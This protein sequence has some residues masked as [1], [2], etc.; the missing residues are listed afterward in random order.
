MRGLMA[1]TFVTL[2]A[3]AG[4]SD[5]NDDDDDRSMAPAPPP[6]PANTTTLDLVLSGAEVVGGTGTSAT[7]TATITVDLDDGSLSGS[8]SVSGATAETVALH[9]GFGGD[10]GPVLVTLESS[11]G[12]WV[13]PDSVALSADEVDAFQNGGL[14]LL[15]TTA[16]APEG[17]LRGQLLPEGIVLLPV[18]LSGDQ[19]VPP[20]ATSASATA[21]VTFD[22]DGNDLVVHVNT[23]GLDD[24]VEAHVHE[25]VAGLNGPILVGLVQDPDDVSHWMLEEFVLDDDALAALQSGA[26]YL[27]VHT[28]ENPPGEVRGQIEPPDVDVFFANLRGEDVVPPAPSDVSGIAAVTLELEARNLDLHV[29][30]AMADDATTVTVN[31]APVMQNGPVAFTLEPD[32]GNAAHWFIEDVSLSDAQYQALRNQGLYVLVET[33]A[34][35]DG[36][37]RG[38]LIPDDSMVGSGDSF[39][40][41]ATDP[42]DGATVAA[43]PEQLTLTFNRAPLASSASVSAIAVTASGGDGTF[44]DGNELVVEVLETTVD[45]AQLSAD[46]D[47]NAA[48]DDIYRVVLDGSSAEPITD[49]AGVVLDGDADGEPGGE[50]QSTFTVDPAAS[51]PTLT[52]LQ[53]EVFTPSCAVSGCHTGGSPPQGLN[54]SA[55]QTF[56]NTVNV[57]ASEVPS[58]DRIEPGDPDASYLVR[59]VEGTASVGGRMPLGGPPLS[60]SQIQAI[61]DWVSA[62]AEDN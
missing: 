29:N 1:V 57:P 60:N 13:F 15:V 31:Q 24:A 59:K 37:A 10:E 21:A 55:G 44:D 23:N 42:D 11:G 43:L 3:L 36:A 33:P 9:R 22:S 41:T 17:A 5:S 32:S 26:L 51:A 40:V 61:R 18:M 52:Q 34:F 47:T 30:L 8:V 58:L 7:G 14:Y 39:V 6:P 4:C 25:A 50:F 12:D 19:E 49:E 46:L 38:Q 48:A 56:G 45:G 35:P 28:P 2:A 20:L 16:A 62:G 27:N 54:L 53:T